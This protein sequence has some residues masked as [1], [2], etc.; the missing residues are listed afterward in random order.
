MFQGIWIALRSTMRLTLALQTIGPVIYTELGQYCCNSTA[1][2][3][4][5]CNDHTH[6]ALHGV[7]VQPSPARAPCAHP[8]HHPEPL[9]PQA[10]GLCTTL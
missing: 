2:P 8:T 7:R 10:T 3:S 6:G 9:P 4:Q 1:P 5:R